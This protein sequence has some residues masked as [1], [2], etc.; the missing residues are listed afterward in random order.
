[1]EA[2]EVNPLAIQLQV[3]DPGLGVLELEPEFAEDLPHRGERCFGLLPCSAHHKQIVC[4]CRAAR[5]AER[6]PGSLVVAGDWGVIPRHN[7]SASRNARRWSG[8]RYR[9]GGLSGGVVRASARSL[10]CMSAW[11]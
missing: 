1:M 5:Y 7:Q 4:L 6:R 2:E 10:I 11:R 8:G 9:P 3:H